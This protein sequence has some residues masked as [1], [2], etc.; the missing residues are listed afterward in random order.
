MKILVVKGIDE[1]K[2]VTD[3]CVRLVADSA[4]VPSGKPFFV[5]ECA[6]RFKGRPA[7]AFRI[8]RLGK[9]ISGQFAHRYFNTVAACCMVTPH[10]MHIDA[11]NDEE[12]A[13]L[14]SFDGSV[15]LGNFLPYDGERDLYVGLHDK[16]GLGGEWLLS[17]TAPMLH[18]LIQELSRYFTLKMG[19]L[20]LCDSG[21]DVVDLQISSEVQG[22]VCGEDSLT[23]RIR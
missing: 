16:N 1:A 9:H 8:G 12:D 18:H 14:Q 17:E 7:L 4:V 23:T 22:K 3:L 21:K 13:R 20:I 11:I 6:K 15:L 2:T 5:P 19:D 10:E